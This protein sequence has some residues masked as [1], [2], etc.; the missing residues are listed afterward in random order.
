MPSSP[1]KGGKGGVIDHLSKLQNLMGSR[2]STDADTRRP[3]S[4]SSS[5]NSKEMKNGGMEVDEKDK[6][7]ERQLSALGRLSPL[8]GKKSPGYSNGDLFGTRGDYLKGMIY[9]SRG[10]GNQQAMLAR[11]TGAKG[12]TRLAKLAGASLPVSNVS[13]VKKKEQKRFK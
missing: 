4:S 12:I 6:L 2:P 8:G 9:K 1:G 7:I 11:K 5:K 10:G 13:I 3:T